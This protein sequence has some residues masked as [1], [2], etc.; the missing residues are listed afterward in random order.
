MDLVEGCKKQD[1]RAQKQFYNTYYKMV[2]NSC[3]RILYD[4]MAAEDCMQETFLKAFA[5]ID[6]IG[7]APLEAWLRRIAIN[8]ALDKLKRNKVEWIEVDETYCFYVD[9]PDNEREENIEW[10]VDQV[11]KTIGKL[12]ENYRLVLTLYLFE[13]YD[14]EE[15]STILGLKETTIRS[16]YARAKQKLVEIIKSE[17]ILCV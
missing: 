4:P 8:T 7:E 16:Q 14:H 11:K 17:K 1:I 15:I 2:Y 3:Y 10:Q 6:T 12:P 9:D 5:K 13:G